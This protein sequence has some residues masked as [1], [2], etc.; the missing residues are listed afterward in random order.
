MA[1]TLAI[2]I[3]W[4]ADGLPDSARKRDL[5]SPSRF[6][7]IR[8]MQLGDG[9]FPCRNRLNMPLNRGRRLGQ[10]ASFNRLGGDPVS[11]SVR[12]GVR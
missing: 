12:R 6:V 2:G 1:S 10:L 3:T 11:L 7:R 9:P 5:Q 4:A 8:K